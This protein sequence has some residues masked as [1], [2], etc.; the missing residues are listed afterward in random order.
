M[1]VQK[2]VFFG[3]GNLVRELYT[4]PKNPFEII[5]DIVLILELQEWNPTALKIRMSSGLQFIPVVFRIFPITCGQPTIGKQGLPVGLH[6]LEHRP[7][8][9]ISRFPVQA[10]SDPLFFPTGPE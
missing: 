8:Q 10:G 4:F 1:F 9:G 3:I 7:I 6:D 2:A 5:T